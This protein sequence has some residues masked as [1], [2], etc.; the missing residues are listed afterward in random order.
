MQPTRLA[1]WSGPFHDSPCVESPE[2]LTNPLH[3]PL[4]LSLSLC[5]I[6]I[7]FFLESS[8]LDFHSLRLL[9][10]SS[11]SS[12]SQHRRRLRESGPGG[13]RNDTLREGKNPMPKFRPECKLSSREELLSRSRPA[14]GSRFR[15]R[16]DEVE[17]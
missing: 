15:S 8:Q 17:G 1:V 10:C 2:I 14:S 3:Q 13:K 16:G 6:P 9:D 7:Q 12:H 11:G 4:S 5:S